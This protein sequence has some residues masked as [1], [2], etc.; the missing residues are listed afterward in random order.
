MS[1]RPKHRLLLD[2]GDEDEEESMKSE[3]KSDSKEGVP[4]GLHAPAHLFPPKAAEAKKAESPFEALD[5]ASID[6][7]KAD[8]GDVA[9]SDVSFVAEAK[10]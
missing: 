8:D 4:Y 7:V 3:G 5:K 1:G 2:L 6:A 9:N 10:P